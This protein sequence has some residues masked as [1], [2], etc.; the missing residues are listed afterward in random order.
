MGAT[1]QMTMTGRSTERQGRLRMVL[2]AYRWE[3]GNYPESLAVLSPAWDEFLAQVPLDRYS[4]AR[5]AGRYTLHEQQ[6]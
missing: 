5:S 3:A 6:P 1:T 2:E 4:Y